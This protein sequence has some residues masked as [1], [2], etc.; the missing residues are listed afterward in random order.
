MGEKL[1]MSEKEVDRIAI[2]SLL[3]ERCLTQREA[4]LRL[5]LSVRQVRRLY[6]TYIAAGAQGI[7]A[8]H[9][10]Q[11]NARRRK[12][13]AEWQAECLSIIRQDYYDYGPTL[14]AEKLAEYNGRAVSKET[15]RQWMIEAGL[16][17]A[18]LT[19]SEKRCHP[20]RARRPCYGELI[21]ID[22]SPHAWFG[23]ENP[24]CT[25]LVFIDDATSALQKLLFVPAENTMGY[26]Q[27]LK[28]YLKQYGKPKAIYSDKHAVFRVNH[29]EAKSG[30]GLT[31][32]GR[33]LKDLDIEI[34]Y[35]HSPQAKGRVER[36]NSTLQDRLIKW[37]RY[38]RVTDMA[39]A[40][41]GPLAAFMAEH[42]QRFAKKH[43]DLVNVHRPLNTLESDNLH[44]LCAIK[45]PRKVSKD[46]TVRHHGLLYHL[47]VSGKGHRLRQTGV[48]VC[49]DES[50]KITILHN[51]QALPYQVYTDSNPVLPPLTRKE[52]DAHFNQR[53]HYQPPPLRPCG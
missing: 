46:L 13:T 5:C 26:L 30:D 23:E 38:H 42:N 16:W 8:K 37:L 10:A 14:A 36:A 41:A 21:Q 19:R 48:L 29:K 27:A 47:Q 52:L 45:T 4:A 11:P 43:P 2:L 3:K 22:G 50:G 25:L 32:F 31:H 44:T 20:L 12:F 7:A 24:K 40:N 28:D 49:E 35:A 18:K 51:Q 15:V 33:V 6:K 53:M 9:R 1:C 17:Q 39:K 34:I